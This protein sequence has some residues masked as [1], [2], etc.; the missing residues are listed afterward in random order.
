MKSF[1]LAALLA[2]GVSG[3]MATAPVSP[4]D[5][6][7]A[8]EADVDLAVC[9]TEGD[10]PNFFFNPLPAML[11]S[12]V[13]D[14][15]R[16]PNK[17]SF[18]R[19]TRLPFGADAGACDVV[20]SM[21][22]DGQ[23]IWN[24]RHAV[25]TIAATKEEILHTSSKQACGP[26]FAGMMD[27]LMIP[28][29]KALDSK[30]PLYARIKGGKAAPPAPAPAAPLAVVAIA[31]LAAPAAMLA[32]APIDAPITA[33]IAAPEAAQTPSLAVEARA[34]KDLDKAERDDL[35]AQIFP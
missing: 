18:K 24:L 12:Q 8:V 29:I 2:L 11:A 3:C 9:V 19:L 32:S 31:P 33:S 27:G 7:A 13:E 17:P 34:Y 5:R 10:K 23:A 14:R 35:D 15:Y 30:G 1:G 20:V 6:Q 25:A 4:E 21:R 16:P 28:I 26:C 22:S